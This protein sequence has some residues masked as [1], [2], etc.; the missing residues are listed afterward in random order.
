MA[1]WC[2]HVGGRYSTYRRRGQRVRG[3]LHR[4][5]PAKLSHKRQHNGSNPQTSRKCFDDFVFHH[6]SSKRTALSPDS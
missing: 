2:S 4:L 1:K 6:L 5:Q 3:T